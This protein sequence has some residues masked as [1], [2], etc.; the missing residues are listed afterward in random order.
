MV[1]TAGIKKP[2]MITG[3]VLIVLGFVFYMQSQGAIGPESSFM[4]ANPEWYTNGKAIMLTGGGLC[5]VAMFIRGTD[6]RK[7]QQ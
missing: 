3:A 5:L 7:K 6:G 2:L 1:N 4:Y